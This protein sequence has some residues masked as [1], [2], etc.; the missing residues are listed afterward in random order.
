MDT[1][2]LS[3]AIKAE[4]SN[5]CRHHIGQLGNR[6]IPRLHHY[7]SGSALINIVNSGCLW[8]TQISCLNDSKEAQY[9]VDLLSAEIQKELTSATMAKEK[10]I[11]EEMQKLVSGTDTSSAGTFVFCFSAREDDLSQWRAYGGG[12][13]CF[14]IEF[15]VHQMLAALPINSATLA[16]CEYDPTRQET[17]IKDIVRCA[18]MFSSAEYDVQPKGQRSC[19]V[20]E[21]VAYYLW[22][23]SFFAPILKHPAFKDE[24]EWRIVHWLRPE[25]VERLRFQHRQSMISRHLPIYFS[26]PRE[27]GYRPLPIKSVMVGPSRHRAISR[28]GVGDLLAS[29]KYPQAVVQAVKTTSTPFRTV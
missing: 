29:K 26:E 16:P 2:H 19:W 10:V 1:R 23:V 12:E 5:F 17:F 20:E 15:D 22:N 27:D 13:S 24:E 21:F 3:E 9:A 11:L 28:I 8:A 7:T 6:P 25:D 14:S 4:V 18:K